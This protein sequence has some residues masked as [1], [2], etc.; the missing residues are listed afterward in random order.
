M[1]DVFFEL[2]NFSPQAGIKKWGTDEETFI[3]IFTSR[4]F[5]QLRAMLP[6]YKKVDAN[7]T[8][9]ICQY[10]LA[11]VFVYLFVFMASTVFG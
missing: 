3:E 6:E 9:N 5:P 4:S 8:V 7:P 2:V 11:Y 1:L 10:L